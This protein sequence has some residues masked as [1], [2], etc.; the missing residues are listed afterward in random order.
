MDQGEVTAMRPKR[1]VSRPPLP[2]QAMREALDAL[3]AAAFRAILRAHP[4]DA[5]PVKPPAK[6][7]LAA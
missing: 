4:T 2:K 5:A 1:G 3:I 6:R 7:L